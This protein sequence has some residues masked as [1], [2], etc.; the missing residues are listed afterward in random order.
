MT[1][2]NH[3]HH[4]QQM[5]HENGTCIILHLLRDRWLWARQ[6]GLLHYLVKISK[7]FC[8]MN[9]NTSKHVCTKTYKV[10]KSERFLVIYETINDRIG[11]VRDILN[12]SAKNRVRHFRSQTTEEEPEASNGRISLQNVTRVER[13]SRDSHKRAAVYYSVQAITT[14]SQRKS[15]QTIRAALCPEQSRV[16]KHDV[17]KLPD[18]ERGSGHDFQHEPRISTFFQLQLVVHSLLIAKTK[19]TQRQITLE[20]S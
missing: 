12:H 3:E 16:E 10:H 19:Q 11:I 4:T 5:Q 7:I 1:I 9:K 18:R 14:T 8:L 17:R 20:K 2:C 6:I 15:L 13:K